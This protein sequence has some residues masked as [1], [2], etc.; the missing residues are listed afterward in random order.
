[1]QIGN[2]VATFDVDAQNTFTPLCPNELPVPGGTEIVEELNA[3][4][5]YAEYRLGS[6]E[7][8]NPKAVW[9]A[10]A[11][12][13]QLESVAG[14]NVDVRWNLHAVPGTLG[15]ELIDGLPHPAEYDFFVWKGIELDMHPYGSCYHDL[16]EKVSTGVIEYLRCHEVKTVIVGGLARSLHTTPLGTMAHEL[17]QAFQALGSRLADSQKATLE[18]WVQEYRGRL[19]IA[20]TDVV[21]IDAFLRDFD[22]YFAKLFD[23]LR[24]DSGDP[25]EWAR[26]VIAHYQSLHI[27]PKS[28]SLVFSD[29]LTIPKALEIY[30]AVHLESNPVFGIGTNLTNDL[31]YPS[32]DMVIK[33]TRCNGQAVAKISDDRQKSICT[34]MAYNSYLA[35]V[36]G[37]EN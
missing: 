27:D 13:P 2:K 24:H 18:A 14:P 19:G 20:L 7:G 5:R 32:L 8:H 26:K 16:A 35:K 25:I 17:L 1:M 30:D 3:Q 15:F 4:A 10:T 37:V 31:G 34:D 6:K 36:I 9:V 23:G 11:D 33:M 29:N 21:G 12:H 22:L 28:K